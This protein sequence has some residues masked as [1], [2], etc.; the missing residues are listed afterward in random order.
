VVSNGSRGLH[1]NVPLLAPFPA[2]KAKAK[3]VRLGDTVKSQHSF[4]ADEKFLGGPKQ[5]S[6]VRDRVTVACLLTT[7]ARWRQLVQ[8]RHRGASSLCLV[9]I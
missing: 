7:V 1:H 5:E 4:Q 2:A 9:W 3:T 8:M 6:V